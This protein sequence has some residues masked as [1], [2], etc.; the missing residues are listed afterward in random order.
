MQRAV[1]A[2]IS[3]CPE[4]DVFM[5]LPWHVI[6]HGCSIRKFGIIK[7][8]LRSLGSEFALIGIGNSKAVGD[9]LQWQ[10]RCVYLDV[11]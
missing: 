7:N 11:R 2:F 5:D 9:R 6:L 10:A 8:P 3:F 4:N 1:E